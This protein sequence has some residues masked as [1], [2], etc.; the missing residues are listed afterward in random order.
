[1]HLTAT[2]PQKVHTPPSV[3]FCHLIM[4]EGYR[5]LVGDGS[6]TVVSPALLMRLTLARAL[7]RKPRLLLLDDADQF[8]SAVGKSRYG[9]QMPEHCNEL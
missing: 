9:G 5:T 3:A 7:V 2:N 1:M 6:G 4:Q 8:A